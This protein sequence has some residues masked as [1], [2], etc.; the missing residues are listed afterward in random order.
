MRS[1]PLGA[2]WCIDGPMIALGD[3]RVQRKKPGLF[4]KGEEEREGFGGREGPRGECSWG[5]FAARAV[6]AGRRRVSA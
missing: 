1:S 6:G 2:S 5:R 3:E 4:G